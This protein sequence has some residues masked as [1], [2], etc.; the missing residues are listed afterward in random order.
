MRKP[1]SVS[2]LSLVHEGEVQGVPKRLRV[3]FEAALAA[4]MNGI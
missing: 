3:L 2:L 1:G 4:L